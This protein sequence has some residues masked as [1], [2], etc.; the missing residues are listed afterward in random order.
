MD[1]YGIPLD[2]AAFHTAVQMRPNSTP[3]YN[4]S[5]TDASS[6]SR[7]VDK[8]LYMDKGVLVT[9]NGFT[10]IVPLANVSYAR[11]SKEASLENTS[12]KE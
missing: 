10:I 5:T 2:H 7:K 1:E 11:I 12:S 3:E 4:L 6:R 9:Q 8:L